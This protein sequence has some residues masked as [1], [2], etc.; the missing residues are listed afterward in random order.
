MNRNVALVCA[1]VIVVVVVVGAVYLSTGGRELSSDFT[2]LAGL[3]LVQ[4]VLGLLN[5]SKTEQVSHQVNGRFSTQQE[6]TRK[7]LEVIPPDAVAQIARDALTE[8]P[9]P[10]GRNGVESEPGDQ[11]PAGPAGQRDP[12]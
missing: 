3:I 6:I 2:G 5:L 4:V 1:T 7:A 11:P 10:D 8:P 12:R 9:A